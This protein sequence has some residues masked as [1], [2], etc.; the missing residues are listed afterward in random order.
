MDEAGVWASRGWIG[1]GGVQG[2]R[3]PGYREVIMFFSLYLRMWNNTVMILF[4]RTELCASKQYYFVMSVLSLF[5]CSARIMFSGWGEG[6]SATWVFTCFHLNPLSSVNTTGMGENAA[7][8]KHYSAPINL[9]LDKLFTGAQPVK[10]YSFLVQRVPPDVIPVIESV[11]Q[12]PVWSIVVIPP[13]QKER[14]EWRGTLRGK[15]GVESG[16]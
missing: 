2:S 5:V 8:P 13:W 1:G 10:I 12:W 9:F 4:S 15:Q 11:L 16:T 6:P 3:D 14:V 7:E